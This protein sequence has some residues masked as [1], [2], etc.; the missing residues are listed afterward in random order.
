M[1][2]CSCQ[3]GA[4]CKFLHATP[5]QQQKASGFGFGAQTGF[6]QQQ[7]PNP[8]GFGVKSGTQLGFGDDSGPKRDQFKVPDYIKTGSDILYCYISIFFWRCLTVYMWIS[9]LQISGP[10]MHLLL[11]HGQPIKP[12]QQI[13]CRVYSLIPRII[14]FLLTADSFPLQLMFMINFFP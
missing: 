6:Q 14:V 13:M 5:Q 11:L 10:V 2:C 7:N 4:R 9:L 1:R 8:F 3:Y 12:N